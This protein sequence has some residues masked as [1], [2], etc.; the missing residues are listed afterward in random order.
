[1]PLDHI[2]VDLIA[3]PPVFRCEH[4]GATEILPM[5]VPLR[6]LDARGR[7]FGDQHRGCRAGE[8]MAEAP[9]S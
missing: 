5:P 2:V 1:M 8:S 7:R 3:Q 6:G 4:C 9:L